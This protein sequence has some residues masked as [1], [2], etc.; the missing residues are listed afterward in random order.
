MCIRDRFTWYHELIWKVFKEENSSQTNPNVHCTLILESRSENFQ[1]CNTE[2]FRWHTWGYHKIITLILFIG[3]LM[4]IGG[5]LL[6]TEVQE[7]QNGACTSWGL[8]LVVA[9]SLGLL[10][11]S[12]RGK[13]ER[14]FF[15]KRSQCASLKVVTRPPHSTLEDFLPFI[16]DKKNKNAH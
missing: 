13:W 10:Q 1:Y 14:L 8:Y 3:I 16:D 9:S 15:L 12:L 2:Y 4:T 5:F 7:G 6:P 11:A